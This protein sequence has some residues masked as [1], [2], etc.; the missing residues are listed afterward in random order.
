MIIC[1]EQSALNKK[2]TCLAAHMLSLFFLLPTLLFPITTYSQSKAE[3][4]QLIFDPALLDQ[5]SDQKINIK[6][7]GKNTVIPQL[8]NTIDFKDGITSL[9]AQSI[10]NNIQQ[11]S[12]QL[13]TIE[14]DSGPFGSDLYETLLDLA[15]QYQQSG[16]HE[17]AIE[18]FERAEYVSRI[19]HGLFHPEQFASIEALIKSY[20][21]TG[22][23]ANANEKQRYLV[24]LSEQYF[25]SNNLNTLPAIINLAKQNMDTYKNIMESPVMPTISFTSLMGTG[26]QRSS[27]P[28][29]RQMAFGSLYQAQQ[30]YFRAIATLLDNEKFF[31]P[32]L[33]ELEYQHLETLLLQ[34]FRSSILM[35]PDYY[36][37]A[38]RYSTGSRIRTN[39]NRRYSS[40]YKFGNNA[41]ER[42]LIYISNNPRADANQLINTLVKHGDW[43]MLFGHTNSAID[44][45]REV[46][47]LLQTLGLQ[48]EEL[49]IFFRPAIPVH[50]PL[51]TAKPNSRDK[52]GISTEQSLE[53][54]GYVD[55]AF[56]ISRYGRAS[57]FE[58]LGM[59]ENASRA[60][61][62]RLKRYL[63]NSPFRPR[64]ETDG[65]VTSERVTLRYYF[66]YAGMNEEVAADQVTSSKGK[67]TYCSAITRRPASVPV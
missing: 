13:E 24:Y 48:A 2:P 53:Y 17:Q 15:R 31:E 33:V 38:K 43:H 36:F 20:L 59:S 5:T 60:I 66:S 27:Q 51:I 34:S 41:F 10:S 25:G 49:G 54:K 1:P 57:K 50:L 39:Y 7:N 16:N 8:Q 61:E 67:P 47:Q 29:Q 11:Y 40:A 19:N 55:I 35:D 14:I 21:A 46:Y 6:G 4:N 12:D 18:T 62:Q 23:I 63:R 52:F 26:M 28:S 37:S 3:L 65:S 44:K 9:P 32:L 30:N 42:M 22:D 56:T 45:Y 64:I 58:T